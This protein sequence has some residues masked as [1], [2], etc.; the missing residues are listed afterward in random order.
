MDHYATAPDWAAPL[1]ATGLDNLVSLL[2]HTEGTCLSMHSRGST[3]RSTLNGG[4]TVYLK[5]DHYT[6][7]K[8]I[9]GQLLRL[10]RPRAKSVREAMVIE[11]LR[12]AGFR[13]PVIIAS[14][15]RSRLLGLPTVA[16]IIMLPLPGVSL[17]DYLAQET[18]PEKRHQA[19]A[20]CEAVLD[21][22]QQ[23]GVYWPDSKPEHFLLQPDG[24]VGLI[25]LE[26]VEFR[27]APLDTTRANR[28]LAHFRRR[29]PR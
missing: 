14:G 13:V 26:R 15:W 8:D 24:T 10:E 11:R 29:L 3:F 5:R 17:E 25:D 20:R 9:G 19:I 6:M 23:R 2:M 1:Q 4:Q 16:G 7:L 28:Q 12:Q 22:F 21:E 27:H 18:D